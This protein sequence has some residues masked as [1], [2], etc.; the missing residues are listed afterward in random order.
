MSARTIEPP[1]PERSYSSA[2]I[3]P[4]IGEREIIEFRFLVELNIFLGDSTAG[5]EIRF[6]YRR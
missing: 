6:V 3:I 4:Q 5:F 2:D 1:F